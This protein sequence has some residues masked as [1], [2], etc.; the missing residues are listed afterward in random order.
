LPSRQAS[1]SIGALAVFAFVRV[2][3]VDATRAPK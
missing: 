1:A 3:P 2:T